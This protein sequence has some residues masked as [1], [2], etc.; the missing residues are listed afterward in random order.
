MGKI[1]KLTSGGDVPLPQ[2][3]RAALGIAPG[4]EV[5]M[6]VLEGGDLLLRRPGSIRVSSTALK[7][8]W[9][10]DLAR[11][12]HLQTGRDPDENMR[13]IRGDDPFPP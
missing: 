8:A 9:R 5:E 3:V 10:R 4:E 2:D 12:T 7:V 13:D 6:E 1:V 11:L